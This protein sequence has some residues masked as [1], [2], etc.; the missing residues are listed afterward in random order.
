MP[1]AQR[2]RRLGSGSAVRAVAV[3]GVTLVLGTASAFAWAYTD[4]IDFNLTEQAYTYGNYRVSSSGDG[5]ASYGPM[6]P[7][8]PR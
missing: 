4:I 7:T 2:Y 8:T 1:G 6:T 5:S 3:A